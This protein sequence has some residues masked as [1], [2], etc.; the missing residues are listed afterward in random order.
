MSWQRRLRN[1]CPS[2]PFCCGCWTWIWKLSTKH[3]KA[4]GTS[5]CDKKH[6]SFCSCKLKWTQSS[7]V[8]VS[9]TI[10]YVGKFYS[11]VA[12][13][14]HLLAPFCITLPRIWQVA[15]KRRD[16]LPRGC[17][18]STHWGMETHRC[19]CSNVAAGSRGQYEAGPRITLFPK[20]PA[21]VFPKELLPNSTFHFNHT[22]SPTSFTSPTSSMYIN[23][24]TWQSSYTPSTSN[25]FNIIDIILITY[26]VY[27][28]KNFMYSTFIIY[29]IY[30]NFKELHPRHTHTSSA[31]CYILVH[32]SFIHWIF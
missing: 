30:V 32:R 15:R 31:L 19:S 25:S 4:W 13:H 12:S 27:V 9:A 8:T 2:Q 24:I 18:R 22:T 3:P 5:S 28:Y 23:I 21:R 26:I 1:S 16:R 14:F 10:G 17:R 7:A 29:I 6:S 20:A 11:W